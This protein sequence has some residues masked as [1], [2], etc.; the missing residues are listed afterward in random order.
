M[1][2]LKQ[3]FIIHFKSSFNKS[4]QIFSANVPQS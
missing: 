2:K 3:A 1:K 4:N